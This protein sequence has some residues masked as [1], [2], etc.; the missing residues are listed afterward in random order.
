VG[1]KDLPFKLATNAAHESV[2][3]LTIYTEDG[4]GAHIEGVRFRFGGLA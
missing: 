4:R 2:R 1:V 3:T